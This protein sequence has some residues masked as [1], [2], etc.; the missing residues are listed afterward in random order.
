VGQKC[1]DGYVGIDSIALIGTH[2]AL[3]KSSMRHSVQALESTNPGAGALSI[4]NKQLLTPEENRIATM[5]AGGAG[6]VIIANILG[7]SETHIRDV[8]NRPSVGRLVLLLCGL[9]GEGLEDG[10]CDLNAAFETAAGEAFLIERN[11]MHELYELGDTLVGEDNDAAVRAKL[12]A[13]T[14][15]QDILDRAGKRAPTRIIGVSAHGNIPAQSLSQ[16]AEVIKEMGGLKRP[17]EDAEVKIT[18]TE[19]T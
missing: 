13:A 14:T 1:L 4:R 8:L 15:A 11:V 19:T 9:I 17:V 7:C 12:G 2:F 18:V 3:D 5:R 6:P 10:I 16:V